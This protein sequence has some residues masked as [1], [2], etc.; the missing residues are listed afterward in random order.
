MIPANSGFLQEN[1]AIEEPT[2]RTYRMDLEGKRIRGFTDGL[3]A[4]VQIVYK[5]LQTERHRYLIYSRNFA[6]ELEDLIGE[7]ISFVIPEIESRI[8]EA[9][10]W[11]TRITSVTDFT[12]DVYKNYVV[13]TFRVYTVYGDFVAERVV[14]F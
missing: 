2:T 9:L 1:F 11:D 10:L 3:E 5:K 6:V 14:N 8:R 12:F 4:M 7:P 13:T